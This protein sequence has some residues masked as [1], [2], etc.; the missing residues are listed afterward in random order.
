LEGET[1]P[2]SNVLFPIVFENEVSTLPHQSLRHHPT[3]TSIAIGQ[4]GRAA[5]VQPDKTRISSGIDEGV[6]HII[7]RIAI[8]SAKRD[9]VAHSVWHQPSVALRAMQKVSQIASLPGQ[10]SR[11]L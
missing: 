10:L 11:H 7:N 8:N 4:V 6:I 3:W 5:V 9:L 2:N 1:P